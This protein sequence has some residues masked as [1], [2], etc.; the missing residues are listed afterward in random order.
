MRRVRLA[1]ALAALCGVT[2]SVP[3]A[4]AAVPTTAVAARAKAA[5]ATATAGTA[6]RAAVP[7]AGA[8]P[9]GFRDASTPWT[10]VFPRDHAAHPDFQTEWWYY[11]G[12]LDA[13][14][15]RFG[16][17]LTFFRVGVA[18]APR[19]SAWAL[20]DLLFAHAAL[21]DENGHRFFFADTLVRP[22]LGRAG[23]DSVRYHVWIDDWHARLDSTGAHT[24]FAD[25]GTFAL[26]LT[27]RPGKPPVI[28]GANGISHK[29]ADPARSSHYASLTRMPTRGRVR[30]A[31]AWRAVSGIS[32]MDHEF[33]TTP[34]SSVEQG[35]DWFALQLDDDR[36]LM[37]YRLRRKDGSVE[38]FSSGTWVEPDGGARP[39]ALADVTI[40]PTAFW[41]S[42]A[43]GARYPAG[44]RLRVP[45]VGLDVTITPTVADQE[46]RTH[47]VAAVTYWEGS[48]AVQ[49]TR[50]G[51]PVAGRGYVELTG[52]AGAIPGGSGPVDRSGGSR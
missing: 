37:F 16:Y 50:A 10:F 18:R 11:T 21:T 45:K 3:P 6:A 2:A 35:W 1:L 48:V 52:Y 4:R 14:D 47:G 22:V 43:S 29:N 28:H 9:A 26:D 15:R 46:L 51:R 24:L 19:A 5:S 20:R 23:A 30:A 49:G 34:T 44:W 42:P 17:E 13:G 8:T 25:A 31:G 39:L 36:E 41:R 27:L 12:H 38:P 7:T 33:M 32:W 40:E